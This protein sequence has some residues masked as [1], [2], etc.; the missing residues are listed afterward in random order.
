[1][2]EKASR[3][4]LAA[5]M[6]HLSSEVFVVIIPHLSFQIWAMVDFFFFLV[7]Y[8]S[9]IFKYCLKDFYLS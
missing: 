4:G 2:L 1:M 6:L 5:F 3:A 7:T 9:C 8:E